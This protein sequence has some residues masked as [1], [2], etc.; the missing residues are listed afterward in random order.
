[1]SGSL[2]LY[3]AGLSGASENSIRL[4]LSLFSGYPLAWL[5]RTP[6]LYNQPAVLK[7]VYFIVT[8]LLQCYFNFGV[9]VYHSLIN[10]IVIYIL[11]KICGGT[12]LSV[13]AAFL[14][15][16]TYLVL[17]YLCE[18]IAKGTYNISW[19]MPHCVLTLRLT[20]VAFDLYDGQKRPV[21][22]DAQDS[23]MS[24]CPSFL[25][26]MG[27]CYFFGGFL[28]GPQFS[29]QRYL[30][31]VHGEYS[32]P[33]TKGPPNSFPAA[34]ERLLLGVAYIAAYQ[35]VYLYVSDDYLTTPAFQ[36]K[37]FLLKCII[38]LVWAKTC[39]NKYIG[40][41]LLIEGTLIYCGLSYN[42]VDNNNVA[43]WDACTNI[44]LKNLETSNTLQAY[45]RSFN[46]NTNLW[47]AKYVF[48][49][50]KFLGNKYVS[51]ALTLLYL[52]VW[53]GM[54]SGYYMCFFLEFVYLYMENQLTL[55]AHRNKILHDIVSSPSL[56]PVIFMVRKLFTSLLL[57]YA[58]TAFSL[59]HWGQ[60]VKVYASMNYYG[61]LI[62]MV[63]IPACILC[64]K[65][66][67][68]K[69]LQNGGQAPHSREEKKMD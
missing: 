13:A 34:L 67:P 65:V 44:R 5:Y 7:H 46:C 60:W 32:D 68:H 64:L 20:A 50:L 11:L 17:G 62:P 42:G 21:P 61:F 69:S 33:R 1:M 58:L 37:G 49:R 59:L 38:L 47:M 26:L 23:A 57:A 56:Q 31:F 3:I 22:I 29:L 15:N 52:A 54:L 40:S 39:L 6:V 8:G 24:T 18:D 19:T 2:V 66:M 30:N 27:H 28:V 25:S 36:D 43:Q 63:L 41:W 48:K 53:H 4:L 16:I 55:V 10:I 51:Q 35:V 12:K 14:Y 45:I 9:H